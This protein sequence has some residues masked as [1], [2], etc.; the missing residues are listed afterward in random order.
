[1]N[2]ADVQ[3]GPAYGFTVVG[4]VIVDPSIG[5]AAISVHRAGRSELAVS[6]D[7]TTSAASSALFPMT[8][9]VGSSLGA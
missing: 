6:Q 1:M 3:P 8:L 7:P 2:W 4:L 5:R 9:P